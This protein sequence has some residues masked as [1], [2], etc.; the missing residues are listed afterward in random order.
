[1]RTKVRSLA[2]LSGLRNQHCHKLW[3]RLQTRLGSGVAV[4]VAVAS[5]Y[6]F[7]K[8][9]AQEPPCAADTALKRQKKKKV[10]RK[11]CYRTCQ[12]HRVLAESVYI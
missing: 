4:A 11:A 3:C 6:S 9:V 2:L 7:I 5:G 12:L 1:M 8:P 10:Q